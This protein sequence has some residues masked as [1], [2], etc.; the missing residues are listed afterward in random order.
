MMTHDQIK[1]I[2]K[3]RYNR[4]EWKNFIAETFKIAELFSNPQQFTDFDT[5]I[6][7]EVW[8]LGIITLP[9]NENDIE[10]KIAIYEVKLTDGVVLE[11]NR[12]GLR[13]LLYKYWRNI[14]GAFI[15]YTDNKSTKWRFTY[16]SELTGFDADGEYTTI[17]TEPK[18]YTYV[19]GENEK[20]RTAIERF[21]SLAKK[22]NKITLHDIKE[23]FSVEKLSDG[24]FDEYKKHYNILCDYLIEKP[25]IRGYFPEKDRDKEIRDF[26]KK[27]LGRI[28]FLYFI[29]KKGWLGVPLNEDYGKGDFKFL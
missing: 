29:Q 16:V 1:A 3:N 15:V 13:N 23:A 8:A 24:F 17:K 5:Q 19:L 25:H 22:D 27:L 18:R 6:A 2:L 7:Q 26:T 28:V 12:V 4:G 21:L 10:R 20:V 11:R 9:E 14:D